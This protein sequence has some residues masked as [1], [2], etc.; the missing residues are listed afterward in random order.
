[1]VV[2]RGRAGADAKST[3]TGFVPDDPLV[4]R[5]AVGV[6]AV[7]SDVAGV[8]DVVS[9]RETDYIGAHRDELTGRIE[10][11]QPGPTGK[12]SGASLCADGI[13]G[14]GFDPNEGSRG[15]ISGTGRLTS[16]KA[17]SATVGPREMM[18]ADIRE[19][20]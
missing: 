12:K 11:E 4:D 13:H 5:V 17:E 8:V 19:R 20:R 10:S 7:A 16:G 1:M 3:G 15:R 14:D 9:D 18:S 6:R 2:E